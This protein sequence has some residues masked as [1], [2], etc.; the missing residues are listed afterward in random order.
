MF[1]SKSFID[2]DE[3]TRKLNYSNNAF[4]VV[5]H[6]TQMTNSNNHGITN[7]YPDTLYDIHRG[8]SVSITSFID[9]II[10]VNLFLVQ[11]L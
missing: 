5:P 10:Y 4:I 3:A 7:T 2:I 1:S 9:E 11:Q 6:A 8:D